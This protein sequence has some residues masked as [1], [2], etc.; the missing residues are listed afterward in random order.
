M[1]RKLFELPRFNT[2]S[3]FL[4]LT[5]Q[6]IFRHIQFLTHP[7]L[8]LKYTHT[9]THTYTQERRKKIKS[10]PNNPHTKDMFCVVPKEL[11]RLYGNNKGPSRWS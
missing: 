10:H 5:R 4:L 11:D 9:H 2:L 6:N 1:G 3:F 8:F 7:I